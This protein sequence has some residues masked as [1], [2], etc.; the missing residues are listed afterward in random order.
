M[1]IL[2]A[3]SDKHIRER[4]AREISAQ[5]HQ[6]ILVGDGREAWRLVRGEGGPQVLLM[7]DRLPTLSALNVATRL[8][9]V[10]PTPYRYCILLGPS[11]QD[12]LPEEIDEFLP[13]PFYMDQTRARL[14]GALR[15]LELQSRMLAVRDALQ[16][17]ATRDGLTSI[18]NRR[19]VMGELERSLARGITGVLLLD[20]DHFKRIND[21]YGH[22]V[23]DDVLVAA[24]R[25]WRSKMRSHEVL[26]R[27]GGEE[28]LAV[29]P[30]ALA[31]EVHAVAER[32]R[33]ALTEVNIVVNGKRVP[34]SC[35][36][37]AAHA[38]PGT[39]E[40]A[41]L[42]KAADDALYRAKREG[43]DR[44]ELHEVTGP[45]VTGPLIH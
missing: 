22:Q 15:L 16:L 31:D 13:P 42:L 39:M 26:G 17:Q 8:R 44:V 20:L 30:G 21:S 11:P 10:N 36:V 2:I 27:Y 28:F 1:Q 23:G 24:C 37:G 41:T 32:L 35:S 12:G 5:G 43:R 25:V 4:L 19:Q 45:L 33:T 38:H 7:Q 18:P 29:L 34:V 9:R 40:M 14:R 3:H 6:C